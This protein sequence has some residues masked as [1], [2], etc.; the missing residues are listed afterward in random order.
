MKH[1]H[2]LLS[3]ICGLPGA[4]GLLA[5]TNPP[6]PSRVVLP[7]ERPDVAT[8]RLDKTGQPSAVFLAAH[9]S[10]L[11]RG[12]QGPIGVLFIGDSITAGWTSV[13][14]QV[15]AKY[16]QAYDPAN[17]AIGGDRTQYVL[18]RIENGE[19]DGISPKVIVLLIGV[20]NGGNPAVTDGIKKVVTEIHARLPA[21]KVLLLGIFPRGADP[22]NPAWN[23]RSRVFT[24]EV[25]KQLATLDDGKKTRFL[26][27]G[28][29][30]LDARGFIS[31]E[32]MPDGLHPALPG[33]QIWAEAMQPLLQEMLNE[34]L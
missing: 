23:K 1:S 5:Q 14:K 13:G 31:P 2:F 22:E 6:E 18:W 12:S 16:Y 30:F 34:G 26:D 15:W 7:P 9:E 33:Y 10:F 25:N 21:S 24:A 19:L 27:I 3:L 32:I 8:M 4:T 20:N 29:K 28:E 11:K 17:F